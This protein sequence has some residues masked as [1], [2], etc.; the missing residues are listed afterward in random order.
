MFKV[1]FHDFFLMRSIENINSIN[2]Y[3]RLTRIVF[4][5]KIQRYN[6]VTIFKSMWAHE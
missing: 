6:Q 2:I 5:L 3:R 4:V 1:I